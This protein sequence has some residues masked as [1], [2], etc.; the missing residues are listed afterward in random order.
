MH[1]AH[2][3]VDGQKMAKSKDNFYTLRELLDRGHDPRAIRWLL[4]TTHYRSPLNFTFAGLAQAASEIQRLE[5]LAARLDRE[6]T[7]DG[8]DNR[9]EARLSEEVRAFE[10]ALGNDLDISSAVGAL[11]RLVR[12]AHVAM[13]AGRLP[14]G[15]RE[16][17]RQAL[18]RADGVFGVMR[19]R[20]LELD[21][22]VEELI[23]R[24]SEA[25]RARD[26]AEADRIRDDLAR[27]GIVLEDTPQGVVWKRGQGSGDGR[28]DG[29]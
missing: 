28:L 18:E 26:W 14:R 3:M 15:S 8:H 16:Q 9:F 12:E 4:L 2:L 13:D 25:R 6:P 21:D 17:L 29:D 22:E 23:R 7:E 24:R 27:R 19:G 5:D 20:Q 11:F 1:T 10:D